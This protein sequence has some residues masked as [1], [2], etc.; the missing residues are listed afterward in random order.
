MTGMRGSRQAGFKYCISC[1]FMFITSAWV[2]RRGGGGTC[3]RT[4]R[5]EK[6]AAKRRSGEQTVKVREGIHSAQDVP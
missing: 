3:V 1:M 2:H 5:R 4:Q 6:K